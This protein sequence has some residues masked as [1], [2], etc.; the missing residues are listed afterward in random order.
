MDEDTGLE[1]VDRQVLA[2]GIPLRPSDHDGPPGLD[3]D[4]SPLEEAAI[5][6]SEVSRALHGFGYVECRHPGEEGDPADEIRRVLTS[7]RMSMLVV[8]IVAHGELSRG[9]ERGLHVIGSDRKAFDDSVS[10]WINLIE[11]YPDKPRPLTLF[12][13]DLCYSGAAAVLPWH[14]EMRAEKRRAWVIAA[15]GRGDRAFDYRLSRATVTVLNRYHDGILQVDSSFQYIPLG[16]I[17]QEIKREVTILG[18]GSYP[19]NVEISRVPLG[20]KPDHLTFFKNPGYRQTPV[21]MLSEMDEGITPML[22]EALSNA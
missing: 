9:G 4:L 16:D 5:C 17:A 7:P 8:H 21:S 15:S 14:Q 6:A 3:E 2:V 20:E 1:A 22:D 19:Q 12:I 13:L 10:Y 18:A 11:S